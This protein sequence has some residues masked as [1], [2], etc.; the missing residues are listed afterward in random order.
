[1]QPLVPLNLPSLYPTSFSCRPST[2]GLI[3]TTLSY[4]KGYFSFRT[5]S[6]RDGS[7]SRVSRNIALSLTFLRC[8]CDAECQSSTWFPAL[9]DLQTELVAPCEGVV[10]VNMC[11]CVHVCSFVSCT[12]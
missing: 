7:S 10:Y 2:D 3:T 1:M 8:I 4:Y 12:N 9:S 6:I 11:A 5:W